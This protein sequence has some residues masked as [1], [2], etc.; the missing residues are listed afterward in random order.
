[1]IRV[2]V[3]TKKIERTL[4]Q[5]GQGGQF[6]YAVQQALNATALDIQTAERARL[7]AE[8]TLRRKDFIERQGAKIKRFATKA[9]PSVEI[10]VDPKADFL[11]KFETGGTK[12]PRA[13]S[14]LAIPEGVRRNKADIVT[15]GNR[16]RALLDRLGKKA[17]AGGVFIVKP[18]QT[19]R[20]HLSPGVYRRDG[21]GGRG[22]VTE[23][24]NLVHSA[25]VDNR[26]HFVD[27]ARRV[28]ANRWEPNMIAAMAKALASARR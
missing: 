14:D 24:F 6:R 10:G 26:L 28:I 13:G 21:R 4:T 3:D 5:L 22:G 18:G 17:G 7:G 1:M 19:N 15:R 8:F 16:P 11:A 2:T 12:T 25:R 9:V 20:G 27:T 23:L